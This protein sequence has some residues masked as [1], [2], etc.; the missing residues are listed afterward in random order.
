MPGWGAPQRPQPASPPAD[1]LKE[2]PATAK[3]ESCFSTFSLLQWMQSAG[4]SCRGTICSKARPQS[5][6]RYS[7]SGIDCCF[8]DQL[9]LADTVSTQSA[10]KTFV[11]PSLAPL[12]VEPQIRF[13]PSFV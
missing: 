10:M 7:K 4:E 2:G 9:L 12:R 13:F 1:S 6:Q 11:S 3:T 8:L 5:L